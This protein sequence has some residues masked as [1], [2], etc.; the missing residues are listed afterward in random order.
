MARPDPS[1]SRVTPK[2]TQPVGQVSE[3]S[4]RPE[5]V[6]PLPP[7]PMYVPAIMVIGFVG[8]LLMILGNYLF[9]SDA[10]G[11][12]SNWYLLGGLGLVLV[13]ILAATQYR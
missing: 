12:P 5:P 7:S 9:T 1:K 10:L 6:A 4:I 2:G 8:G 11:T 13:G 3:R